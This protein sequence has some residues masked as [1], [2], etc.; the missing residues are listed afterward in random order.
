MSKKHDISDLL[1][2]IDLI[3]LAVNDQKSDY[4]EGSPALTSAETIDAVTGVL[5]NAYLSIVRKKNEEYRERMRKQRYDRG[6]SDE[7]VWN[8]NS[9]FIKTVRPMLLQLR[10]IHVGS[11]SFPD[12][13]CVNGEDHDESTVHD[14]WDNILDRMIFLLG[15][16][17]E[18][19]RTVRNPFEEEFEKNTENHTLI[20][21]ENG[22]R[23]LQ[24]MTEDP[25][26]QEVSKKYFEAE[27]EI[28]AYM[29][30]CKNEFFELFSAHFWDLWD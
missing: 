11:P 26:Y 23:K 7:D 10:D 12:L 8:I 29:D 5:E 3:N 30:T 25:E 13:Q 18:E 27:K 15:E 21:T 1:Y 14:R 24:T 6:F 16:M 20:V 2:Y 28:A 22:E 9:W 4:S 19:T 17:D